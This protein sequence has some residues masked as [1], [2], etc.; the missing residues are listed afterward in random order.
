VLFG[1]VTTA[2]KFD[3]L[4]IAD[5]VVT[6]ASGQRA[7][8]PLVDGPLFAGRVQ[9]VDLLNRSATR[10][11]TQDFRARLLHRHHLPSVFFACK[12]MAFSVSAS[13]LRIQA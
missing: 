8:F 6:A 9:D 4:G 12:L 1:E 11:A 2:V 5:G 13:S 7:I 3:I 10:W